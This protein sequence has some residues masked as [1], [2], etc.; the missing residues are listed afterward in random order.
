MGWTASYST[1]YNALLI[2]K[3][4]IGMPRVLGRNRHQK[5]AHRVGEQ[6]VGPE[7]VQ[8]LL[9]RSRSEDPAD[10]LEA[11]RFLCPCHVRRRLEP[12][13]EALYR[14][15]E[16]PDRRVRRQA[17][18][19]LDDGGRPDDPAFRPILER[20]L[21]EETDPQVRRIAETLARPFE[22]QERASAHGAAQAA[23]RQRGR[24][25]FCAAANVPV[26]WDPQTLI[27]TSGG[28]RVALICEACAR[29][30]G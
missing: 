9:A 7:Q 15:L 11:A 24:C 26:E 22:R 25:D 19:T 30:G 29:S 20:V 8:Q 6:R 21:R 2:E 18:H 28:S 4:R 10:R 23:A 13:W 14:M 17:W 27:P 3:G 16:D 12:V 1:R 5:A